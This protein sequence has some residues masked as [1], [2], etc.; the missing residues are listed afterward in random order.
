MRYTECRLET[1]R[2]RDAGRYRQGNGRLPAELRRQ[3]NSNHGAAGAHPEPADQ[4][5]GWHRGGMATV[6]I[7][8]HTR[9][10]VDACSLLLRKPE[11]HDR[12]DHR[13]S[14]PAPDFPPPASSMACRA[15]ATATAPGGAALHRRAKHFTP[16]KSTAA[17]AAIIVD[18]LPYHRSTSGCCWNALPSWSTTRR[19][20]DSDIRDESGQAGHARRDRAQARELPGGGAEQPVR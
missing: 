4:R 1:H 16:R 10:M 14:V 17:T 20:T 19:S 5:F 2:R 15:C 3:A 13:V 11:N 8:P 9:A 18:E 6:N 12:R 7:P